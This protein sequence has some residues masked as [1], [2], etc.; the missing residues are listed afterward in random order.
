MGVILAV[1]ASEFMAVTMPPV[2]VALT[3]PFASTVTVISQAA[4]PA[5]QANAMSR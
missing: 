5:V 1:Y 3:S 2:D 4:P